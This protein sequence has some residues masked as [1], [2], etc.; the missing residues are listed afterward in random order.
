[1]KILKIIWNLTSKFG[2]GGV[3]KGVINLVI[4]AVIIGAVIVG[5]NVG[6]NKVTYANKHYK[7]LRQ[8]N[9]YLMDVSAAQKQTVIDLRF[10]LDSTQKAKQGDSTMYNKMIEQHQVNTRILAN[11]NKTQLAIIEKYRKEGRVC[12]EMQTIKTG[13]LKNKKKLVEIDCP[14]EEE[15]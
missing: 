4:Y 3:W 2:A 1:M 15:E 8:A 14:K 6:W 7:N 9:E 5:F 11:M 13:F 10:T 12:F